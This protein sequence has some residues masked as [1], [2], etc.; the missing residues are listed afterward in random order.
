MVHSFVIRPRSQDM[1]RVEPVTVEVPRSEKVPAIDVVVTAG[2]GRVKDGG[3]TG[4]VFQFLDEDAEFDIKT[5]SVGP[6]A[7]GPYVRRIA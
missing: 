2:I 1:K 5:V 3:V 7:P 6:Y 4:V